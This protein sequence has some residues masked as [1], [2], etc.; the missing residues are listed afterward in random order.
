MAKGEIHGK[1]VY[2]GPEGAGK[3]ANLEC[4]SRKLKKEHRGDL[5]TVEADDGSY[6]HLPVSLGTVK[7]MATSIDIYSVPG[8]EDHA[9]TRA[10]LLESV[11]GVVLVADLR[12]E[13]HDAT[14]GSVEELQTILS[15]SGR[16]L[17][18]LCLVIQYNHADSASENA[19]EELHRRIGIGDATVFEAVASEG[20]GVLQTLTSLSKQVL[21]TI[22]ARGH[23]PAA[24]EPPPADPVHEDQPDP[25]YDETAVDAEID[26]SLSGFGPDTPLALDPPPA[27]PAATTASAGSRD[28]RLESAGEPAVSDGALVVP[29][30]LRDDTSGEVIALSLRIELQES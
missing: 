8:A 23:E 1:I 3:T 27:A 5:K 17:D 12:P 2:V 21:A 24:I 10:R 13:R 14:L 9:A 26:A 25:S 16:T 30:S 4:L 28:L 15:S 22:R 20:K 29:I 6:E 19:V 11:D 18:E 7:G